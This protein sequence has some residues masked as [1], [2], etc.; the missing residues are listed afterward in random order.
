MSDV[1]PIPT[2]N[3]L[4]AYREA[5][6]L[7]QQDLADKLGVS[8]GLVSLWES[9]HRAVSAEMA[10][11]IEHRLGIDRADIRKDLFKRAAA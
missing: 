7:S 4:K 1:A 10:V 3:P 9:G 2:P 5:Q 6:Q 11:K 8:R